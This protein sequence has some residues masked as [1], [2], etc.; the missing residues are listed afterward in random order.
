M[1]WLDYALG[2]LMLYSPYTQRVLNA[3]KEYADA[4]MWWQGLWEPENPPLVPSV[5][6]FGRRDLVDD[7]ACFRIPS[8][9]SN[10][11]QL[12]AFAE[13]R[14][15]SCEDDGY[16]RI[17]MKL[18]N[19]WGHTWSTMCYLTDDG[20]RAKNPTAMYDI[21]KHKLVMHYTLC[22]TNP[23]GT[24]QCIPTHANKQA[25]SYNGHIWT[26]E[27]ITNTF[28]SDQGVFTGPGNAFYDTRTKRYLFA[29]HYGTAYRTDGKVIV[30]YSDDGGLTYTTSPTTLA[31]MD[32]AT[33]ARWNTTHLVLN[34]RNTP[35]VN[36][37]VSCS[38]RALSFSGDGGETWSNVQYDWQ[39]RDSV[40]QG[41]STSF[42][43]FTFFVHPNMC[44]ARANMTLMYRSIHQTEWEERRI[45]NEFSFSDYS[46]V[47][48]IPLMING[49]T[50][51]GVL[52]GSCT[53]PFPFRVWCGFDAAW[54]VRFGWVEV[55]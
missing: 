9:V 48:Q 54:T 14:K 7:I 23:D 18:S 34:M 5:E 1:N 35:S 31:H 15:H 52:W 11:S 6:V 49:H 21:N 46:S 50:N 55:A 36:D 26:I 13:G 38:H 43:Q 29:A 3:S 24:G 12:Y 45:T 33:M 20:L 19:D 25:T 47:V 30:Y 10:G 42:Q 17:V 8:V 41:S 4:N 2:G 51:V 27:D 22:S 39:M 37:G 32:E 16:S 44:S 53:F 40:C 28:A